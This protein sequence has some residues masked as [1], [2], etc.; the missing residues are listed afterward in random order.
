[1]QLFFQQGIIASIFLSSL[2][3]LNSTNFNET[4][5]ESYNQEHMKVAM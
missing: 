1:M 4:L 3:F 2:Q 5:Y